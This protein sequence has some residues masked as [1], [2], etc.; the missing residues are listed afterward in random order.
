V[1]DVALV[2]AAASITYAAMLVW[3]P[4]W[5]PGRRVR[6]VPGAHLARRITRWLRYHRFYRAL[7]IDAGR[8]RE[9][10]GRQARAV[11]KEQA[12]QAAREIS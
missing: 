6:V 12:R 10:L 8:R 9:P 7:I 5:R 2:A 4:Y 1:T 3:W 11:M